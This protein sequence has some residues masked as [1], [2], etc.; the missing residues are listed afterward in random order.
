MGQRT[1]TR[2]NS[3]HL[4]TLTKA[5][6]IVADFH[7]EEETK[8]KKPI[9]Y[10]FGFENSWIRKWIRGFE[11][12]FQ[13]TVYEIRSVTDP[14]LGD[15]ATVGGPATPPATHNLVHFSSSNL[16]HRFTIFQHYCQQK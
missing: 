14:S 16:Q 6:T 13:L 3:R 9:K 12:G 11:V 4:A 5:G 10:G 1:R 8:R 7:V 15:E 2:H